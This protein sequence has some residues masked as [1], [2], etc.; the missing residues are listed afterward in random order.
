MSRGK[1]VVSQV[2]Y[3]ESS[4]PY[5][6]VTLEARYDSKLPEDQRFAAATPSGKIEMNVTVPAVIEA[7]EPGRVFYV[8]FIEA[9]A[10]TS[11]M[12]N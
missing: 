10:G 1:F 12:H 6:N 3:Y 2:T 5:V 11:P 9:P 4:G 8:D 7:F